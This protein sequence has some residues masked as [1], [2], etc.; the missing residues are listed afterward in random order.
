MFTAHRIKEL[1][2]LEMAGKRSKA[3][4][5]RVCAD[6]RAENHLLIRPDHARF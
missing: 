2:P 6:P 5:E 3:V 1:L 4:I